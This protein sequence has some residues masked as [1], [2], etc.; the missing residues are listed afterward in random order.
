M[1]YTTNVQ[2]AIYDVT[3]NEIIALVDGVKNAGWYT[4]RWDCRD[5]KGKLC[6]SGI[7]FV[8]LKTEKSQLIRKIL[9]LR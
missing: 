7:Y 9:L 1:K 3:G 6:P 4:V 2:I 8:R 5:N